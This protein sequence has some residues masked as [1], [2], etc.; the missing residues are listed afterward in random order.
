M[1]KEEKEAKEREFIA[2]SFGIEVE[3]F[4]NS[5]IGRFL[6]DRAEKQRMKAIEAFKASTLTEAD[7]VRKLQNDLVIPDLIILWLRGAIQEGFAAVERIN[8][9]EQNTY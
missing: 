4:L 5:A 8:E 6:F 7:E 3:S 2:A 9:G 1:T